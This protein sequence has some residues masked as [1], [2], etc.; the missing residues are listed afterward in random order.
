MNQPRSFAIYER[1]TLEEMNPDEETVH[2]LTPEELAAEQEIIL[3]E[4]RAEAEQKVKEAYEEGLRRGTEAGREHFTAQVSEA[5]DALKLAASQIMLAHEQFL[6]ALEPQLY[7]ILS[8]IIRKLIYRELKDESGLIHIVVRNALRHLA[9]REEVTLRINPADE[10]I[11]RAERIRLLEEFD[12]I[13]Q[14]TVLPDATITRGGCIAEASLSQVDAR[15]ESQLELILSAL[16]EV[17]TENATRSDP[18]A[19]IP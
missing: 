8:A 1:L 10:D 6:N 19:D 4:A 14:I 3:A 9:E 13:R 18:D 5:T 11:L 12:G 7:E 2:T 15:I 16:L 17:Q